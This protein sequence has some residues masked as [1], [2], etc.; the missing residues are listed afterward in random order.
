MSSSLLNPGVRLG[1][2][3]VLA[4]IATGG[5]GTVYK[6]SDEELGRLVALK[7]LD[8]TMAE[9]P[10]TL[11]R[12][13]REARH[14]A[15]L[16]HKNIVTLYEYGQAEGVHF[17]ALEFVEGIDLYD[18]IE[19]KG[20]LPPEESRRILIQAVQALDHAFQQNIIHRDIKPSNF[21]LTR[22]RDRM[23]VKLTDMGL[24]LNTSEEAFRVT[25]AGST[26]GTIDYLSPEQARNSADADIRSDIY[27]LGCTLYH[28]LAGKPPFSEGG[29][30][31]RILKHLQEDPLDIRQFNPHVSEE[32]WLLLKRMLAKKAED[33]HQTPAELLRALKALPQQASYGEP[34]R[35]PRSK[36][37][38]TPPPEPAEK[39]S[40]SATL[41]LPDGPPEPKETFSRPRP[42]RIEDDPTLLRLSPE[43]LQAAARQYERGEE[44]R[45][46]GNVDYA[47]QMLLGCVKF[48]PASIVYREAL[49]EVNKVAAQQRGLGGWLSSLTTLA[50]RARLNAAKRARQFRKVLEDGEEVLVRHPRDVKTQMAMAVSA[51][52]LGLIHLASW[53]L[54][55]LRRQDPRYLPAHRALAILYEK[56]RQY[57]DAIAVWELVRKVAP[58]DA[59][60]ARKINDLAA[61]D[62]IARGNYRR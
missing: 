3:K 44:A 57:S 1:K 39:S 59:E 62:T 40:G 33:R 15:R 36:P 19:R 17:L 12:F 13:R 61:S 6:A 47:V 49:R 52:E 28:M 60:A 30:G 42:R 25:R 31:E 16:S 32:M 37:S 4:H 26:V 34:I 27:S 54:E 2:Y 22:D 8:A 24:A 43:H 35:L 55:E 51:E 21:L 29:L 14:A 50:T 58:H 9:K 18:Y 41:L 23:R 20:Q 5:M 53:M 11:E 38:R 48:N 45:A 56:Q 7:V 46:N 10:N